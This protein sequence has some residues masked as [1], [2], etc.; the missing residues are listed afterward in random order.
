MSHWVIEQLFILALFFGIAE[1]PWS[2]FIDPVIR[3]ALATT[4]A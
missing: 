1:K 3:G 4:C 2:C